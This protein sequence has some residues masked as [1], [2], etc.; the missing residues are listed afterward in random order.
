MDATAADVRAFLEA[1][2][3]SAR[4]ARPLY[5][6]AKFAQRNR[7]AVWT[8]GMAALGL[9]TALT[10]T[11]LRGRLA[12]ALGV[13]LLAV[14]A[15]LALAQARRVATAR[16]AATRAG[17]DA[18]AQLDRVKRIINDLVFRYG[19]TVTH[20]PGGA[21]AQE[22]MLRNIVTLLEPTVQGG[23]DDLDLIATMASVLGRL[24]EIQGNSL[25]TDRARAGEA[26]ATAER[27]L[28]LAERAWAQRRGDWRFASWHIRTLI[29]RAHLLRSR[30]QIDEART[31]LELAATRAAAGLALQRDGEGHMYMGTSL[32]NSC[33]DLALLL[34]HP[35]LPSFGD[36]AQALVEHRRSEQALRALLARKEDLAALD[37]NAP[38]GEQSS[39]AYL[40]HQLGT[41]IGSRALIHLRADRV[42][43]AY[44]EIQTAMPLRLLNVEREPRNVWWR[45]GLMAEANVWATCLLR[46]GRAAE[47]LAAATLA[48]DTLMALARDEGEQSKWV[49]PATRSLVGPQY[50]WAL[51]VNGRPGEAVE[52]LEPTLVYWRGEV[53]ADA[54]RKVAQVQQHLGAARAAVAA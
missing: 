20:M 50:G 51:L 6:M 41:I 22:G 2:P 27:A 1:R 25:M 40:T 44:A 45:H 32:A 36:G 12:A 52:V 23:T 18:R 28:A 42:E 31:L 8:A 10:A 7:T 30:G 33:M 19:D 9:A 17:D 47:G 16:D 54:Q 21:Q 11:I 38:P 53:G 49:R 15:V 4:A 39:Q 37:R 5:L 26:T 13:A 48:W 29:V 3:V 24:A 14:A 35:V 43:E 46:L 34:D